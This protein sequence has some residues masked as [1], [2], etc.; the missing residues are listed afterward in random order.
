MSSLG[1]HT[2]QRDKRTLPFHLPGQLAIYALYH[3]EA[4]DYSWSATHS[5]L[6]PG[7]EP[8]Y[9]ILGSASPPTPS[10]NPLA[11]HQ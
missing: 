5:G 8:A 10:T 11:T 2:M 4:Y 6:Y 1:A 9:H 3:S 7:L